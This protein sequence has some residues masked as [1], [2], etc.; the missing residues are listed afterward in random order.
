MED[1]QGRT[2]DADQILFKI[3]YHSLENWAELCD[4]Q[5]FEKGSVRADATVK[6]AERPDQGGEEFF[7]LRWSVTR[8]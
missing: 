1:S 5:I 8:L 4:G 3:F 6:K 7:I 2:Q